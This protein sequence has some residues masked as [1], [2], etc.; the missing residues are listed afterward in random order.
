M[1]ALSRF[2]H[3]IRK[4]ENARKPTAGR[5]GARQGTVP[6][7]QQGQFRDRT[8]CTRLLAGSKEGCSASLQ[9]GEE[10]RAEHAVP[11]L[12]RKQVRKHHKSCTGK[13]EMGRL[14]S[15]PTSTKQTRTRLA[16]DME[17]ISQ[18]PHKEEA[19]SQAI[20]TSHK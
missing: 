10:C 18:S 17:L 3:R 11:R 14:L 20:T 2:T 7:K 16:L 1:R 9:E 4:E 12:G 5:N 8:C 6:V 19:R 15:K 13:N